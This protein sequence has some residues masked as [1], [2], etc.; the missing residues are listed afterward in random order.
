MIQKI[1]NYIVLTLEYDR[2]NETLMETKNQ[3]ISDMKIPW[4]FMKGE[5]CK[6]NVE[7]YLTD[8]VKWCTI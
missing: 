5:K 7:K 8:S 2:S 4:I 6:K 3:A 1:N